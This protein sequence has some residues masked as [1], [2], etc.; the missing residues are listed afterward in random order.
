[1]N[2]QVIIDVTGI[3]SMTKKEIK[4][5]FVDKYSI[6]GV[7]AFNKKQLIE[8]IKKKAVATNDDIEE[9]TDNSDD[10][11]EYY[12]KTEFSTSELQAM[13]SVKIK[14]IA[15]AKGINIRG[16]NKEKLIFIMGKDKEIVFEYTSNKLMKSKKRELLLICK[17]LKISESKK[18]MKKKQLVE[19]I[20]KNKPGDNTNDVQE[21]C[22]NNSTNNNVI[23]ESKTEE[24]DIVVIIPS[25]KPEKVLQY[26][27]DKKI[28]S[29]YYVADL[30]K[31]YKELNLD[32]GARLKKEYLEAVYKHL[33]EKRLKETSTFAVTSLLS[34]IISGVT[35]CVD[36]D[37]KLDSFDKDVTPGDLI[38]DLDEEEDEK[39]D[40]V[41]IVTEVCNNVIETAIESIETIYKDID[42]DAIENLITKVSDIKQKQKDDDSLSYEE[43]IDSDYVEEPQN[44]R[45]IEPEVDDNEECKYPE[46]D[47]GIVQDQNKKQVKKTRKSKKGKKSNDEDL[48]L[49]KLLWGNTDVDFDYEEEYKTFEND[50]PTN[51]IDEESNIINDYNSF[52]KQ[53]QLREMGE[54]EYISNYDKVISEEEIEWFNEDI[55]KT[56]FDTVKTSDLFYR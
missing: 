29:K 39:E 35:V 4:A 37:E 40:I 28:L 32:T 46:N 13:K 41:G 25:K 30:K 48:N 8:Y 26:V 19:L 3:D 38:I 50:I 17:Q 51:V 6:K 45:S 12:L 42:I 20:L 24:D 36:D 9:K 43:E 31:M 22:S 55:E 49:F 10:I 34:S 15:K 2:T 16:K 18:S 11:N 56:P 21:D 5:N 44:F 7:S 14:S 27:A 23:E 33:E 53:N 52:V 1:M 47:N 54:L